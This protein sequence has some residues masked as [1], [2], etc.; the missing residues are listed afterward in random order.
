MSEE[1]RRVMERYTTRYVGPVVPSI[2]RTLTL[3]AVR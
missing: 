2:D 3:R 1:R